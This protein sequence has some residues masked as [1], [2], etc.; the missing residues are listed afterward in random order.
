[1]KRGNFAWKAGAMPLLVSLCACLTLAACGE[2]GE[3]PNRGK[4]GTVRYEVTVSNESEWKEEENVKLYDLKGDLKASCGLTDGKASFDLASGYYIAEVSGAPDTVGFEPLLFTPDLRSGNIALLDSEI[5]TDYGAYSFGVLGVI[6]Q[7]GVPAEG[8]VITVCYEPEGGLGFC[9]LPQISDAS[10]AV[11]VSAMKGDYHVS[12]SEEG[13]AGVVC[14]K[15]DKISE[16]KRFFV[17]DLA[18]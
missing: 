10:G 16:E 13:S 1:M 7:N 9:Y 6:V 2:K 5:N 18:A 11:R 4:D 17:L 12:A 3:E 14:E 8:Y 15:S